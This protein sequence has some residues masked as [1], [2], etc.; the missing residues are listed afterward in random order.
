MRNSLHQYLKHDRVFLLG[1]VASPRSR[2]D[3]F[4]QVLPEG[5][6]SSKFS[7]SMNLSFSFG[8]ERPG[9]GGSNNNNKKNLKCFTCL[10]SYEL[11]KV[12]INQLF[13][14]AVT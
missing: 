11:L 8:E 5:N 1:C 10:F 14:C 2:Q 7:F 6:P 9:G 3:S 4:C 12:P 13:T